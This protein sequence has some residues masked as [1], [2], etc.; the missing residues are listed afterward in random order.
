MAEQKGRPAHRPTAKTRRTVSRMAAMGTAQKMIALALRI[1]V[2]TLARAYREEL[3]TATAKRRAEAIDLLWAAMRRGNVSAI[4][5]GLDAMDRAAAESHFD[6]KSASRPLGKKER[7]EREA[8]EAG[9]GTGWGDDLQ[10]DLP[11]EKLN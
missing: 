4:K 2:P 7:Q 10:T 8:L 3:A 6:G 11:P 9:R 1:S 5:R